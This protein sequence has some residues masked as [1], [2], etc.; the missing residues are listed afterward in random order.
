VA[1]VFGEFI[2]SRLIALRLCE[3]VNDDSGSATESRSCRR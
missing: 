1:R 2:V 3:N